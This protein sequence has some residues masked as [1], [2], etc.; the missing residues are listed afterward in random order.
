MKIKNSNNT[1]NVTTEEHG[2]RL[3]KSRHA[4]NKRSNIVDSV[5]AQIVPTITNVRPVWSFF[6]DLGLRITYRFSL[7]QAFTNVYDDH[8]QGLLDI[9]RHSIRRLEA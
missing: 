8:I 9:I 2:L 4:E 3:F 1:W 6:D 7:P 5:R